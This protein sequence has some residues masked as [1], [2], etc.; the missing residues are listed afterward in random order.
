[1]KNSR[2]LAKIFVFSLFIGMFSVFSLYSAQLAR[3]VPSFHEQVTESFSCSLKQIRAF[4]LAKPDMS[5]PERERHE[6][7]LKSLGT[8]QMIWNLLASD[9]YGFSADAAGDSLSFSRDVDSNLK[10]LFDRYLQKKLATLRL[11]QSA[12]DCAATMSRYES[13]QLSRTIELYAPFASSLQDCWAPLVRLASVLKQKSF[14]NKDSFAFAFDMI[15]VL[16]KKALTGSMKLLA[17]DCDSSEALTVNALGGKTLYL[18][19]QTYDHFLVILSSEKVPRPSLLGV[20]SG[21]LLRA[22]YKQFCDRELDPSLG[23]TR[24]LMVSDIFSCVVNHFVET[25]KIVYEDDV[26]SLRINGAAASLDFVRPVKESR[27]RARIKHDPSHRVV[28]ALVTFAPLLLMSTV[29]SLVQQACGDYAPYVE[30]VAL[31]SPL[32]AILSYSVLGNGKVTKLL[33]SFNLKTLILNPVLRLM[34]FIG[35][36]TIELVAKGRSTAGICSK[37][38][39]GGGLFEFAEK[40]VGVGRVAYVVLLVGPALFNFSRGLIAAGIDAGYGLLGYMR[41]HLPFIGGVERGAVL[42][43]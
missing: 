14:L 13:D 28:D 8:V 18:L 34:K 35:H 19:L 27:R 32:L 25:E 38:I 30:G 16:G 33:S 42:S 37:W 26:R 12:V 6:A 1:M 11:T 9:L 40:C 22:V 29:H 36:G 5:D 24:M 31:A 39:W 15:N 3:S 7:I 4:I 17:E 20:A 2:F 43:V 23:D 21:E 41:D 10:A